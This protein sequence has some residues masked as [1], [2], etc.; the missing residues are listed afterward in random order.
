MDL[1]INLFVTPMLGSELS[2][3]VCVCQGELSELW[4]KRLLPENAHL[5]FVIC[6][7]SHWLLSGGEIPFS[8]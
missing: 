6:A 7:R 3:C 4:H 2:V 1:H 8:I 5:E